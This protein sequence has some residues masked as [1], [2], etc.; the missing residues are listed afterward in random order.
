MTARISEV[1]V[2]EVGLP[3]R[4]TADGCGETKC[5]VFARDF[6]E[7]KRALR[8]Y[9]SGV[10]R[11]YPFISAFGASVAAGDESRLARLPSVRAVS[12]HT[13]ATAAG[14]AYG[15][16]PSAAIKREDCV[17]LG[18]GE[19]V[20]VA[21]IDTGISPHPD[22]EMPRARIAEFVDL[23]GGKIEPYDDNGHGTAV[24]GIACG[25]G[26]VSGGE[27]SGVAPLSEAVAI[28]A[29]GA[30][31]DGSAFDILEAMQWVYLNHARLNIRVV[32]AS[33]GAKPLSENDPLALGAEALWRE[34]VV[35]V[36]SAGNSGPKRG[37]VNSPGI[38]ADAITVG[39]YGEEGGK[40]FVPDFSSR[41]SGDEVK[42]EVVA[43]G[44]DVFC[45]SGGNEPYEKMSGTSMAAPAIAGLCA[46]IISARPSLTP[47]GVK[48]IVV[49]SAVLV[50]GYES[51]C[52]YGYVH[53]KI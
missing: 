18:T 20:R 17:R 46:R 9:C 21:V 38:C 28:K 31:G 40:G 50:P 19:G 12:E 22:F 4:L 43:D 44:V 37:S 52:G 30:N 45:V 34:G 49:N 10:V 8:P 32:C 13:T 53:T 14:S 1:A 15:F 47:D 27:H 41:G 36:A 6:H 48:E 33:F 3:R 5:V 35:V 25:N 11:C 42:P 7:A 24:A 16:Y 23:I 26:L 39:A 29:L 51:A 2:G